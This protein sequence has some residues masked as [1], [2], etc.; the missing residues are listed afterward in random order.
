MNKYKELEEKVN[1]LEKELKEEKDNESFN[2]F[3]TLLLVVSLFGIIGITVYAGDKE[4]A[5]AEVKLGVS[6]IIGVGML[7]IISI[8]IEIS[9]EIHWDQHLLI[10]S[11][12]SGGIWAILLIANIITAPKIIAE[13]VIV[14]V[15]AAL[16]ALLLIEFLIE[17]IIYAYKEY[18]NKKEK[19]KREG[20]VYNCK[21]K[22]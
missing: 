17:T 14:D 9:E 22:I 10:L 5:I 13:P 3:A 19:E 12:L 7:W 6:L 1:K 20:G 21:K 15:F 2:F 16:F 8:I 18:K 4:V 11:L